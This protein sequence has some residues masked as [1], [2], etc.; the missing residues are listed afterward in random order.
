M[1]K[2]QKIAISD[3]ESNTPKVGITIA[4]DEVLNDASNYLIA[5]VKIHRTGM[6]LENVQIDTL[7]QLRDLIAQAAEQVVNFSPE[8]S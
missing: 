4:D 1:F 6:S 3:P 7:D 8:K 2:I 5:S